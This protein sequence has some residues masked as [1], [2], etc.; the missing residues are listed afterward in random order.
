MRKGMVALLLVCTTQIAWAG[1]QYH[2]PYPVT[3]NQQLT[4]G[5]ICSRPE[6]YRYPEHIK[7][8]GRHV[9]PET[10]RQVMEV[11]DRTFGYQVTKMPRGEF[12]ID[13]LIPLC[14]GGGNGVKNLWPQHVTVYRE[15]DPLEQQACELMAEG[16]LKQQRAIELIIRAKTDPTQIDDV[17]DELDQLMH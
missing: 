1:S 14:A 9:E 6:G 2:R 8:C 11:Y 5:E 12:K 16:R 4:P 3:P 15:T 17:G 13:H 10:K 7:Y